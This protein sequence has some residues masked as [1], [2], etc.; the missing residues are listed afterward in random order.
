RRST[1]AVDG[2]GG[3]TV[4]A[5][6]IA[7]SPVG[8]C[9]T[10]LPLPAGIWFMIVQGRRV[11]LADRPGAD[12]GRAVGPGLV[13]ALSRHEPGAHVALRADQ[14]FVLDTDLGPE[15]PYFHIARPAPAEVVIS[16]DLLEQV[17]PG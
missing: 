2:A 8:F 14:R 10:G 15:P 17:R 13:G 16:P 3:G 6:D 4:S 5:M 7:S 12:P 1:W 9:G 11:S